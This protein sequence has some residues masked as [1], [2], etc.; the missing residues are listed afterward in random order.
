MEA[1]RTK[2]TTT[3][4]L[5]DCKHDNNNSINNNNDNNDKSSAEISS[6]LLYVCVKIKTKHDRNTHTR[7]HHTES[8]DSIRRACAQRAKNEES[9][10]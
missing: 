3:T 9:K 8:D 4:N 2:T 7:M 6:K 10:A 1:S 5:L